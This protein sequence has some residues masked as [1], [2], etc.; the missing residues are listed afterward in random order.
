M[1]SWDKYSAIAPVL[2]LRS[3]HLLVSRP[4][5]IMLYLPLVCQKTYAPLT[6]STIR[7]MLMRQSP[8]LLSMI[9]VMQGD[10]V[11]VME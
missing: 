5:E 11:T 6:W 1:R 8:A 3:L 10:D 2:A 4:K 7:H 9:D